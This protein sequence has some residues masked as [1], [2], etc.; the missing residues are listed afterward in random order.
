MNEKWTAPKLVVRASETQCQ[1]QA[2]VLAQKLGLTLADDTG[3]SCA[4]EPCWE[5]QVARESITLMRADG[6]STKIDFLQGKAVRRS[7]EKS[8]ASQPLARAMG[9]AKLRKR[10]PEPLIIDAT[11]GYGLDSW[12]MASLACK[13]CMLE[14]SAVLCAMLEHALAVARNQQS[15][16]AA[17]RLSIINTDAIHFLNMPSNPSANIVYLDPMYPASRN[18]ALVK[19]GMQLLHELIGPDTNGAALLNAALNNA[20]YRVIV[21]RPKG[22]AMLAGSENWHGQ[23]TNVQSAHTRFDVYHIPATQQTD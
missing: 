8:F 19:K 10:T 14:A 17:N 21:K 4:P 2:S 12:M 5:L 18:S 16:S 6:L 23:I 9:L 3:Q 11:A 7:Q 22:A 1:A 20:D 13:V 15:N